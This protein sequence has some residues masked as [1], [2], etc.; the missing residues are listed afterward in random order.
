MNTGPK[1]FA[2][3]YAILLAGAT[4]SAFWANI[5]LEFLKA[6]NFSLWI[7]FFIPLV[8]ITLI[9]ISHD[10][11]RVGEAIRDLLKKRNIFFELVSTVGESTRYFDTPLFYIDENDQNQYRVLQNSKW[12]AIRFHVMRYLFR[13]YPVVYYNVTAKPFLNWIDFLYLRLLRNLQQDVG[14]KIVIALH[15][16]ERIYQT[17]FFTD[18]ARES[19]AK[20]YEDAADNIRKIL[21][22][23]SVI[24][25][26]RWYLLSG[27]HGTRQFVEYFFGVLIAKMNYLAKELS[28][29]QIT[30]Q[31]YYRKQTNLLS[32]L[33]TIMTAKQYGHLYV[34]DYEGSFSIW[35][36][37]P[38]RDLKAS[39]RIFFIKCHKLKGPKGE[40][41]PSWSPEDG[42]NI[43]D[44]TESI[45][46][47]I[48]L[49]DDTVLKTMLDVFN[50]PLSARERAT[51]EK[52]LYEFFR[53]TKKEMKL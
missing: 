9:I 36:E 18:S 48:A 51:R 27:S 34:L 44:D 19:Y 3:K 21:G 43:T 35:E 20:L 42:I 7:G 50:I 24:L 38:L 4:V 46:C 28:H 22:E 37:G 41:L 30:Y 53:L 32:G 14:A 40:R 12:N 6:K 13:R 11:W 2:V 16:D 29:G 45:K 8:L 25:D 52:E 1:V 26:E 15:F 39:H 31:E 5:Y 49:T 10:V 23:S 47:K 33:S 17:G